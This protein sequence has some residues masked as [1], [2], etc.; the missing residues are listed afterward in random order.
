[1]K[2][3]EFESLI[4]FNIKE[5][6]KYVSNRIM[7]KHILSEEA[8]TIM[9]LAVDYGKVYKPDTIAFITFL[10]VLEGKAEIVVDNISTFMQ[11]DDCI[12][13]P[14]HTPFS[15]EANHRF[16]IVLIVLKNSGPKAM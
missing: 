12:I 14:A 4:P 11:E 10:R 7:I 8:G 6:I 15:L 9:A 16:K 3:Y 2:N 13:V 5:K 1:M